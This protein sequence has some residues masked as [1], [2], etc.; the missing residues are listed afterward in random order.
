MPIMHLASGTA[1]TKAQ[2]AQPIGPRFNFESRGKL[3]GF[4]K[5]WGR[6]TDFDSPRR[7]SDNRIYLDRYLPRIEHFA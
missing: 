6:A 2:S 5:L 1:I 4:P 7:P 3:R